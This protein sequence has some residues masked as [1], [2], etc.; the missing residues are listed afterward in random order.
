M[1][2]FFSLA[3]LSSLIVSASTVQSSPI[4]ITTSGIL[5]GAEQDGGEDIITAQT[6]DIVNAP[7]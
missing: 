3:A 5:Q 4:V 6:S 1:K 7:E 2:S